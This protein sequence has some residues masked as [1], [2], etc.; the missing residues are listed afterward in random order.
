MASAYTSAKE[1][2]EKDNRL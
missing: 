1:S 2:T